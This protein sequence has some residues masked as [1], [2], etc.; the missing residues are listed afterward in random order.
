MTNP[1]QAAPEAPVT[2]RSG[3][4]VTVH[5][6]YCGN[7][8]EHDLRESGAFQ[9]RAPGCGIVRTPDQRFTGYWFTP[10]Y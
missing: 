4:H 1:P 8:H 9:R 2:S 6:P 10:S 5:C 3:L 7:R